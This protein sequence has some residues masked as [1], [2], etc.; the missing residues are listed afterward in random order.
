MREKHKPATSVGTPPTA[1]RASIR[2][3]IVVLHPLRRQGRALDRKG[4]ISEEEFR[5]PGT[6]SSTVGL[7]GRLPRGYLS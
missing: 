3:S 2:Y 5:L 7:A 4:A 1:G 6:E